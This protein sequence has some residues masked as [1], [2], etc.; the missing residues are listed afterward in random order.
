MSIVSCRVCKEKFEKNKFIEGID[1]IMPSK[2]WY[3]HKKCYEDWK[4]A[5]NLDDKDWVGL[6][7]DFLSHDLKVPYDYGACESQRKRFVATNKYTNKGI[8]FA[9]KYFYDIR[10]GD[11]KKSNGG[12]GIIP[13]IY[14]DSVKYWVNQ[15][16]KTKGILISIEKQMRERANRE[17][18]KVTKKKKQN[19]QK[20][21]Y[22]LE[23]VASEENLING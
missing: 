12:I 6:I 15:E 20:S 7:Y 4:S 23:D 1:W 14:E 3:Y 21:K 10:K 13:H 9:L 18:I 5:T 11:W 8:Y 22:S 17:V 2:N 19:K 16:Y